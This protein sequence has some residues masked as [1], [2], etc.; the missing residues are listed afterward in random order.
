MNTDRTCYSSESD[1]CR[2]KKYPGRNN[3]IHE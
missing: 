3:T 1:N 2:T